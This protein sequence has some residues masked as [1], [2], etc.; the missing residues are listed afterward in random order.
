MSSVFDM[1]EVEFRGALKEKTTPELVFLNAKNIYGFL[2]TLFEE[3]CNDSVLREWAFQWF[4][5]ET[6]EKYD[7]IYNEWLGE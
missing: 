6:G 1:S 7:V 3:N 2:S 5:E 4:C